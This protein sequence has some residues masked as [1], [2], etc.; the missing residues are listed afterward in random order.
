MSVAACPHQVAGQSERIADLERRNLVHPHHNATRF[1]RLTH[2]VLP[3][4]EGTV[5]VV[6]EQVSVLR[7]PGSTTDAAASSLRE[8]RNHA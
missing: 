6:A 1:A 5:E 4:K 3:L 7:R 8:R 2:F